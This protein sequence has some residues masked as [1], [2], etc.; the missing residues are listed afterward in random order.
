MAIHAKGSRPV[1]KPSA[2]AARPLVR[3]ASTGRM[4]EATPR[5]TVP[6]TNDAGIAASKDYRALVNATC[7]TLPKVKHKLTL[8]EFRRCLRHADLRERVHIERE[9]VP[10]FVLIDLSKAMGASATDAQELFGIPSATYKKKVAEKKPFGGTAGQSVVGMLD[11]INKV[12]ELLDPEHPEAQGFNTERWIGEW[13]YRPQPA[14]GG[15]PPAE[16]ID[17]PSGREEVMRLL[18]AAASGA[19]L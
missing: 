11:L 10:Y 12:E 14:L 9:G 6:R 3:A 1:R 8:T 17:T 5:K 19:Y 16:F 18:G 13:I 15:K 2:K 4:S 7:E